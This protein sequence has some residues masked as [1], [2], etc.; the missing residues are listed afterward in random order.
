MFDALFQATWSPYAAGAG[1]GVLVC[2]SFLLCNRPLGTS[3][4]YVKARG[5]LEKAVDPHIEEKKEYYREIPPRVDGVL[6]LLP[7]ILIGAF[8]SAAL[9]GQFH[10]SWVPGL[11]AAAFGE[12]TFVR[13]LAAFAGGIILAFGAQWAGGCTSGHG[14]S[15]TSQLSLA[16]ILS[17]ACFFIGG[18]ITAF[19]IF[20]GSGV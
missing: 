2:L 3:S 18:I 1:I 4:A 16:S 17:A 15:G 7:G 13:L 19:V 12:N 20:H 9:S 11:W 8:I 14:I 6:M 5:L 10:L